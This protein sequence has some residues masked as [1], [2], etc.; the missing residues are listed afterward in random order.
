MAR[1]RCKVSLGSSNAMRLE[2]QVC[3]CLKILASRATKRACKQSSSLT[4]W[5]AQ[6]KIASLLAHGWPIH[7]ALPHP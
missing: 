3:G 5:T 6:P 7:L 4:R 2:L 1:V